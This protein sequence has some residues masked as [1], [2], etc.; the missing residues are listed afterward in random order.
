[1]SEYERRSEHFSIFEHYYHSY[2]VLRDSFLKAQYKTS[3]VQG[4]L[5]GAYTLL[6]IA[7]ENLIKS[8]LPGPIKT[9]DL[10]EL[11][12]LFEVAHKKD[13]PD[14]L[15]VVIKEIN[16]YGYPVNGSLRYK[17][18]ASFPLYLIDQDWGHF[19]TTE[20]WKTSFRVRENNT[21]EWFIRHYERKAWLAKRQA[22]REARPGS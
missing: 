13:T 8:G 22:E 14:E 20:I 17:Y 16:P 11:N 10:L 7:I 5:R 19:I 9:H 6:H 4:Y 21:E 1:M 15:M 3:V 12:R 2:K 18:D